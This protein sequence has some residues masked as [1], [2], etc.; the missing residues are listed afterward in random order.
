MRRREYL[1]GAVAGLAT[2][3]GCSDSGGI[4]V[5][6]SVESFGLLSDPGAYEDL[7]SDLDEVDQG[8]DAVFGA[9]YRTPVV[10]GEVDYEAEVRVL[11]DGTEVDREVAETNEA[12]DT[13]A[14]LDERVAWFE[15]AGIGWEATPHVAEFVVRDRHSG[16]AADSVDA[17][18]DVAAPSVVVTEV[19]P[20]E[21]TAPQGTTVELA[22]TVVNDGAAE[23]SADVR[24][25]VGGEPAASESVTL[26]PDEERT[27]T[28]E[29]G[30]EDLE[31]GQHEFQIQSDESAVDG[32]LTVS[33]PMP[34]P[35][36][37]ATFSPDPVRTDLDQDGR[38]FSVEVRND[39]HGGAVGY[40]LTFSDST[41]FD[42]WEED[43]E[44]SDAGVVEAGAQTE[45][46]VHY[47]GTT[48]DA[49][50]YYDFRLWPAEVRAEVANEG[51]AGGPV[52]VTLLDD[53]DPVETVVEE[54]ATG[55]TVEVTFRIEDPDEEPGPLR[56]EAEA[57]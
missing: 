22:G 44:A 6:P 5:E 1:V 41:P 10:D 57:Q 37:E 15:F 36:V 33:E 30:T 56:V 8:G 40:A 12:V 19:D 13:D 54:I 53:D 2:I 32:T 16:S 38:D 24:L 45:L 21:T 27:L 17:S 51:V 7:S 18:F 39:G 43:V 35:V 31:V 34:D 20:L 29:V 42:P 47:G 46:T 11:I 9:E 14:D 26:G 48:D 49:G 52:E 23:T 55:E 3:A 25:D 4:D 50:E 28:F